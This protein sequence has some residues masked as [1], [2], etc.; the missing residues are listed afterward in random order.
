MGYIYSACGIVLAL[1][2][3]NAGSQLITSYIAAHRAG[4]KLKL[5]LSVVSSVRTSGE[6]AF[7]NFDLKAVIFVRMVSHRR[8]KGEIVKDFCIRQTVR[9]GAGYVIAQV[10]NPAAALSG[11]HA[12]ATGFADGCLHLS[13]F[14]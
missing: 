13:H 1:F 14:C 7:A 12:K 10:E 9:N 6:S 5:G 4:G 3:G 2:P 11:S 8:I